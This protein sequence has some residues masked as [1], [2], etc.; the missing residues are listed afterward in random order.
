MHVPDLWVAVRPGR[1]GYM[2]PALMRE[3]VLASLAVSLDPAKRAKRRVYVSRSRQKWRPLTNEEE[4]VAL[5]A[6]YGFET[7]YFEDMTFVEQV[8]TVYEAAVFI[9][10][11]EAKMTKFYL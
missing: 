8:R 5:L 9:G 2:I 11:H 6:G 7:V 3:A 4:I 1:H 10:T